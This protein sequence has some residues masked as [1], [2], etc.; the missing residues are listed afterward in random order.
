MVAHAYVR[1]DSSE[2]P[3]SAEQARS[4]RSPAG[5]ARRLQ[6]PFPGVIARAIINAV[7]GFSSLSRTKAGGSFPDPDR[8]PGIEHR[9][10]GE[11]FN[12]DKRHPLRDAA[13]G[14]EPRSSGVHVDAGHHPAL[15]VG[16]HR[17]GDFTGRLWFNPEFCVTD[18]MGGVAFDPALN[19][20]SLNDLLLLLPLKLPSA[21]E[22]LLEGLGCQFTGS[23]GQ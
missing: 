6:N 14:V 2:L 21:V 20:V 23:L 22:R 11:G 15:A 19:A 18:G 4:K 10:P 12:E 9:S 16:N 5:R 3:A 7:H 13:H 17:Q 1:D 8:S